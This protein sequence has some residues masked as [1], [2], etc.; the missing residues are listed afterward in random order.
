MTCPGAGGGAGLTAEEIRVLEKVVAE[1]G[2]D[3]LRT[4]GGLLDAGVPSQEAERILNNNQWIDGFRTHDELLAF[5]GSLEGGPAAVE[6]HHLVLFLVT[7]MG[8]TLSEAVMEIRNHRPFVLR[9]AAHHRYRSTYQA[10]RTWREVDRLSD[11]EMKRR[12]DE[13]KRRGPEGE[14]AELILERIE[15]RETREAR[16][17]MDARD[18]AILAREQKRP[19]NAPA[20]DGARGSADTPKTPQ[21]G[22]EWPEGA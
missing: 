5:H 18:A 15:A 16:E 4:F 11:A 8:H 3:G 17:A 10:V 1:L 20:G 22:P 19:Q 21:A 12:R 7:E 14:L 6:F 13:Y 2:P 9:V